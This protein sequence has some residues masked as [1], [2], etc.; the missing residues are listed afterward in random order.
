MK[1]DLAELGVWR[2]GTCIFA[3]RLFGMLEPSNAR[4]I[5]VFDAFEELPGYGG[6]ASYLANSAADV[7][8]N[9]KVMG[10]W[11]EHVQFYVGLFRETAKTFRA[12]HDVALTRLAVLRI[13]GNFYDSAPGRSAWDLRVRL[14]GW[15]RDF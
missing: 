13:D 5:H 1:G 6:A 7:R 8:M 3:Q 9:F 11:T 2:G 10:A 15:L 14:G 12:E 4:K